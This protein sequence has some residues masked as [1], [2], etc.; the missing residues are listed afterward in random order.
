MLQD[1]IPKICY[2]PRISCEHIRNWKPQVLNPLPMHLKSLFVSKKGKTEYDDKKKANKFLCLSWP[3]KRKNASPVIEK[4][5]E[6]EA[7]EL[8]AKCIEAAMN[9]QSK[10]RHKRSVS[11]LQV[12]STFPV[13]IRLQR[14]IVVESSELNTVFGSFST[15]SEIKAISLDGFGLVIQGLPSK[16]FTST[17]RTHTLAV[18]RRSTWK[19]SSIVYRNFTP[20]L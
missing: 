14:P 19:N 2:T 3:K 20:F 18:H 7:E 1:Y 5:K 4:N 17:Y 6:S 9:S 13:E 11:M 12:S 10:I 16:R 15:N 8:L